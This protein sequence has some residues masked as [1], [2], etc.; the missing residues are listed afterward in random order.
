VAAQASE[1]DNAT[2]EKTTRKDHRKTP[3]RI[4][5][6]PE[7]QTT[8]NEDDWQSLPIL[9]KQKHSN[10]DNDHNWT[11]V[12]SRK[13]QRQSPETLR[14]YKQT[15]L[16]YWLASPTTTSNSFALLD[17]TPGPKEA[18]ESRPVKPPPLFVD[19]VSNI[20]PLTKMLQEI[21]K[22]DYEI[23]T[24][25][26][27]RV[28]IQLKSA[29]SFSAVY[30]ELKLRNTEFFT[31][32]PKEERSFKVVLKHIHP[33]TDTNEISSALADLRH[34]VTNIWNIKH[35][36]TMQLLPIF[37]FK[38]QPSDNNKD[39][40]SLKRPLRTIPQCTN[41]QDYRHTKKFCNRQA[42]CV[43]YAKA[44]HTVDCPR[45]ERSDKVNCVLWDRNNPANYKS[46]TICKELQKIT[47]HNLKGLNKQKNLRSTLKICLIKKGPI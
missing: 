7:S 25:K 18:I 4:N 27:Q 1:K 5:L 17:E 36:Q 20:Q 45:K 47:Q 2:G 12:N 21:V 34:N 9:R 37:Y 39:I 6:D 15:K 19:K 22:D 8:E 32:Q 28:K 35:R 13:R 46:C 40:Y 23:K 38:L 31:Y 43:K 14:A 30:K 42:Q 11:E 16:N 24:L 26:A 29:E 41:C 10:L 33:S 44:H 3:M